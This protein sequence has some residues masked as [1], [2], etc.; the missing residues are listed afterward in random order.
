MAHQD[1]SEMIHT[2]VLH[3][4]RQEVDPC[5]SGIFDILHETQVIPLDMQ[6]TIPFHS[7]CGFMGE[8]V[9]R[10]HE[11][12]TCKADSN[13]TY[14]KNRQRRLA[15]LMDMIFQRLGMKKEDRDALFG[16]FLDVDK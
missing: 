2:E 12:G 4:V 7:S 9:L 13:T 11:N 8:I 6:W 1:K 10:V 15:R 14:A 16:E 3:S 5:I